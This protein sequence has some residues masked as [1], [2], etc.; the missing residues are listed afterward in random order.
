MNAII[1]AFKSKTVWF[2]VITGVLA[3]VNEL[4]GKVV[5]TETAATIIAIGN[6]ILRFVTTKPLSAK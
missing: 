5:P 2:N 6:V 1:G 3:V 4:S